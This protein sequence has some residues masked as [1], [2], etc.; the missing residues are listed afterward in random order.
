MFHGKRKEEGGYTRFCR[1]AAALCGTV[2]L[3]LNLATIPGVSSS[4]PP[5]IAMYVL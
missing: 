4:A 5:N 2:V 3:L 1:G